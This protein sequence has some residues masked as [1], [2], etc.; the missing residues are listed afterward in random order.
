M[1]SQGRLLGAPPEGISH[2]VGPLCSLVG[3]AP[4]EQVFVKDQP[5]E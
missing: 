5:D 1:E 4:G 3:F 2:E